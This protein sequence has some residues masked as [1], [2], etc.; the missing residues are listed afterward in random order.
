MAYWLRSAIFDA[1]L[2]VLHWAT[3]AYAVWLGMEAS[4]ASQRPW[5]GWVTGLVV[6]AVLNAG[7]FWMDIPLPS[8][9]IEDGA[10]NSYRR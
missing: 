1:G 6:L 10:D 5:V 9:E 3:L 7:L 2:W 8:M 4:H